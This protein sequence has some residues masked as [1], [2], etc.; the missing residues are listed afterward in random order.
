MKNLLLTL[1]LWLGGALGLSLATGC[2]PSDTPAVPSSSPPG[3][4]VAIVTIPVEGMLCG[5]CVAATRRAL[6]SISGVEEVEVSLEKR[7]ARVRYDGSKTSP[8]QLAATIRQ[9]GYK[10]GTPTEDAK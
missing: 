8:D 7:Q 10:A 9:L 2:R 5:S 4:N 3:G 6:R 1:L